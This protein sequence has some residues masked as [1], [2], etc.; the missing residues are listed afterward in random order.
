MIRVIQDSFL[1]ISAML[2]GLAFEL[3]QQ[4]DVIP[5]T[6]VPDSVLQSVI[7]YG[8]LG[9]IS[10]M[11]FRLWSQSQERQ[12][13]ITDDR[14]RELEQERDKAQ[15]Y[16]EKARQDLIEEVRKNRDLYIDRFGGNQ[17]RDAA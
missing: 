3:S 10:I 6:D 7:E 8:L 16:A 2:T 12:K 15:A 9:I 17:K 1:L 14:I 11:F 13:E 4:I 5:G